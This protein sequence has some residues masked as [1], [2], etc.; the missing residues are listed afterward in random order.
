MRIAIIAA[1]ALLAAGCFSGLKK[2]VEQPL[3]YRLDAPKW[4]N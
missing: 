4:L 2:E 1:C 3:L